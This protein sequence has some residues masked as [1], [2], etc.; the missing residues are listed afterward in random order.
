MPSAVSDQG[1]RVFCSRCPGASDSEI[2]LSIDLQ[3]KSWLSE[4][5]T[6]AVGSAD[7]CD[8]R[9]LSPHSGSRAWATAHAR[10]SERA[11]YRFDWPRANFFTLR[12]FDPRA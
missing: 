9:S 11:A 4:V 10:N 3:H 6:V 1:P 5:R 12:F 2:S 8:K 7:G